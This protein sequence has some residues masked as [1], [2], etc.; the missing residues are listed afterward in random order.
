LSIAGVYVADIASGSVTPIAQRG[1]VVPATEIRLFEGAFGSVSIDA[2]RVAFSYATGGDLLANGIVAASHDEFSGIYTTL[3]GALT[4]VVATGDVLDGKVV[5][6][7][8]IGQGLDGNQILTSVWFED[9]TGALYLATLI[10]EPATIALAAVAG[11][12]LIVIVRRTGNRRR[13]PSG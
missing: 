9:G 8:N 1:M 5:T 13:T 12:A 2:G 3:P 7:V 6:R 11:F 4:K 10:P